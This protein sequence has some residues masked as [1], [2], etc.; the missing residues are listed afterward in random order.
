M[1]K[2][3]TAYFSPIV[4]VSKG[5][6]I[7]LC[8]DYRN[9]NQHNI[10][11]QHALPTIDEF[12]VKLSGAKFFSKLDLKF[13][14]HQLLIREDSRDLIVFTCHLGIF[15]YKTLP[16]GLANDPYAPMEVISCIL[17][18]GKNAISYLDDILIFGSSQRER[19]QCCKRL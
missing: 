16:F 3:I 8:V 10:I 1:Q 12:F 14:Y 2:L 7:R 13:A 18:Q 11:D 19:D 9:I 5:D 6:D 4:V 15:K 17:R